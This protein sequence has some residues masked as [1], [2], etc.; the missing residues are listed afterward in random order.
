[1]CKTISSLITECSLAVNDDGT[2]LGLR[3]HVHHLSDPPPELEERVAEWIAVA[4]PLRV[5]ELDHLPLLTVLA[6]PDRPE[7][8]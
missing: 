1:M 3:V 7:K 4:R 6:Q 5:V 8:S 2:I